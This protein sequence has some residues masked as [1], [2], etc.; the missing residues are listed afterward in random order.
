[1]RAT[2]TFGKSLRVIEGKVWLILPLLALAGCMNAGDRTATSFEPVL[3]TARA[4]AEV[5][6]GHTARIL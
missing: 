5:P 3:M 1:V 6:P 4:V 2:K